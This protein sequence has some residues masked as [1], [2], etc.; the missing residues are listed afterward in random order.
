MIKELPVE[1]N[2]H[3]LPQGGEITVLYPEGREALVLSAGYVCAV[4]GTNPAFRAAEDAVYAQDPCPYPDGIV[5]TITLAVPSGKMLV[6][7][8]LRPVYGWDDRELASYNS[9]LG[10]AQ[11]VEAMAAVGCAYGPQRSQSDTNTT[12]QP[13]IGCLLAA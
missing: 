3:L 13:L 11:A 10:Q 5:T 1:P 2:G 4:C 8:D 9:V 12:R 6:A 7:D